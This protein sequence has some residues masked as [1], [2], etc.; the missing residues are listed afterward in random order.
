MHIYV[1]IY[2][3]SHTHSVYKVLH[4][5]DSGGVPNRHNSFWSSLVTASVAVPKELERTIMLIVTDLGFNNPQHH[6]Y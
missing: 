6:L 3:H 4:C 5:G 1:Y 2:V